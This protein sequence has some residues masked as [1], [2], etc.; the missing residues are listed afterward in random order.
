[1]L[2]A[3]AGIALAQQAPSPQFVREFQAGVDAYRLGKYDEARAHLEQAKAFEPKLP[4][5]YR[6]LAAVDQSESKFADCVADARTAIDLN[7]K[8]TE[9]AETIK[10]HDACRASLGKP[11]YTFAADSTG[12][13]ISVTANADAATV[14]LNGLKYGATP[15]APREVVAGDAEIGVSKVG[16]LPQTKTVKVLA[17]VVT[18]VDFTLEKDP[19]FHEATD[20]GNGHPAEPV[21][22]FLEITGTTN[23]TIKLDGKDVVL[24]DNKLESDPGVH[25]IEVQSPGME[26]WRRRVRIARGQKITV[27]VAMVSS[28]DRASTHGKGVAFVT[29]GAV[30]AAGALGTGIYS[31]RQAEIAHDWYRIEQTRPSGSDTSGILPIHTRAD[32]DAQSDKAKTWG[33]I[34]DAAVGAAVVSFGV[35][36]YFFLKDRPEERPGQP[37]PFAIAPI[38]GNG[39]TGFVI[40]KA[41]QW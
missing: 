31:Y 9:I 11:A 37:A 34:S 33:Y 5:P 7:P 36:V 18:D 4:G 29:I 12:G 2:A 3:S 19:N 20:V 32:I 14:T 26:S 13:A 25:E 8:S 21:T 41:V 15:L 35:G 10:L 23:A 40:E 38:L 22:G 16:F 6:Y 1:M 30:L 17:G 39:D 28:D 27:A 24:K